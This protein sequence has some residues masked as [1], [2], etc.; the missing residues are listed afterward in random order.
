M[1]N[2]DISFDI[3]KIK[4]YSDE[5]IRNKIALIDDSIA[6]FNTNI[7]LN[8]TDYAIN[9]KKLAILTKQKE[10][11]TEI[12]VK[13]E[14]RDAYQE[15]IE[16]DKD[17]PKEQNKTVNQYLNLASKISPEVASYVLSPDETNSYAQKLNEIYSSIYKD[18]KSV[19]YLQNIRG[20]LTSEQMERDSINSKSYQPRYEKV[21]CLK[22]YKGKR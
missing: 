4:N 5:E 8:C 20:Y 7:E 6:K 19:E 10:K 17:D 16:D 2:I 15:D 11:L 21:Y 12:L 22:P 9:T 14:L 3:D 13:E 18:R 1:C